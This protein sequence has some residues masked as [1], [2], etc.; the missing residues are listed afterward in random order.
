LALNGSSV[1][2][3]GFF[4]SATV[5]FGPFSLTNAGFI[6]SNDV[7]VAKLT[8]AGNTSSFAWAQRAGN[9]GS[10]SAYA[11][12]VSGANVYV[13]GY[14]DGPMASFGPVT[15]TNPGPA[16]AAEGFVAKL[17]DAGSTGGFVWAQQAGGVGYDRATCLSASGATVYVAGFFASPTASFGPSSLTSTGSSDLFV[18]KLT[19]AGST[20]SFAWAQRAGG[21]GSDYATALNV[22]GTTLYVSGHIQSPTASFGS[23]ALTNPNINA[24][25]SPDANPLGYLASLTDPTLTATVPGHSLAPAQ[26]YPNPAHHT[27]TLHLP[28][29]TAPAPL[30]LTD[31]QGRTVRRYPAPAGM[32]TTLDLQG[33]PAGLYLLRGV[34]PAQR[35]AVE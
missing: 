13:A 26:L 4:N 8:D 32:E 20:G 19:D 30:T 22:S 5:A 12:A 11:L 29:G 18:A 3:A 35:L 28:A 7:F 16:N 34:G 17:T 1:Y 6:N 23:T 14:F 9:T 27:A 31:A 33:L 25:P 10:E 24:F 15:L 21:A 2:V